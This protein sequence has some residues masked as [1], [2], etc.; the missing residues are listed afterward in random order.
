MKSFKKRFSTYV[1]TA[2][3]IFAIVTLSSCKDDEDEVSPRVT[4]QLP[5]ENQVFSSIDTIEASATITDN[6]QL[7]SVELEI[8]DLDFNQVATKQ[9][10]PASGTTFNFGQFFPIDA[11]QLPT[12]DYYLAFRANDG[13]NVGSGFVKIKINAIPR[14]LEGVTI[15]TTE[16]NQS[17]LYYRKADENEF[18]VVTNFFSDAVGGGLNYRENI[19]ATAGGEAGEAVF[20]ETEEYSTISSLPGF[21]MPGT[22]YFLSVD[23]HE[24]LEQFTVTNREGR[25]RV[26]DKNAFPI[27]GFDGLTGFLPLEVFES[28]DGYFLSEKELSG[29]LYAFTAYSFQGLL[30]DNYPVAGEVK[31]LYDRN[32][33]EKYVWVD[34]PE[35]LELRLLNVSTEF[36]SLPYERPGERLSD[37]VRIDQNSFILSTSEG[38]LR[39]NYSNGGTIPLSDSAPQGKLFFDDLNQ[40]IYLTQGTTCSIY[41]IDGSLLN[42]FSFPRE[43]KYVGFDYNR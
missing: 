22:S 11:P 31:G 15:L 39:Y 26:F 8:L 2:V 35:G 24:N 37:V 42:E 43:I 27:L 23:Y 36:L 40:L 3:M 12:G 14:E 21:G 4:I 34:D 6:E 33:N 41:G 7:T 9:S 1:H 10:Y 17:Y 5:F 20:L 16:S 19:F 13:S 38:L 29:P 25:I 18:E 28:E 32:Q 30:L